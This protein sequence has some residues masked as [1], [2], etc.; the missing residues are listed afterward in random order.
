M[1]GDDPEELHYR[2]RVM[3]PG[4]YKTNL[5]QK[6]GEDKVSD[7]YIS[8][9][10]DFLD[11]EDLSLLVV[12][13]GTSVQRTAVCAAVLSATTEP[14]RYW[15][16][17]TY[18]ENR[19]LLHHYKTMSERTGGAQDVLDE[20]HEYERYFIRLELSPLLVMDRIGDSGYWPNDVMGIID[21][22]EDRSRAGLITVVSLDRTALDRVP[23]WDRILQTA[24]TTIDLGE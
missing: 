23:A 10:M 3:M 19:K 13:G 11:E 22:V 15:R 21:M 14:S 18:V 24:D 6:F 7:V 9:A 12:V 5:S 17:N 20:Y 16:E 8:Q 2:H 1:F 4:D